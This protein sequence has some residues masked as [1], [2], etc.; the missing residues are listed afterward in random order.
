ML[1]LP[2]EEITKAEVAGLLHDLGHT[3]FSYST[4]KYLKEFYGKDHKDQTADII[5]GAFSNFPVD[6]TISTQSVPSIL[7]DY[8]YD[9]KEIAAIAVKRGAY[10]GPQYLQDMLNQ[11]YDLDVLDSVNRWSDMGSTKVKINPSKMLNVY[12]IYGESLVFNGKRLSEV[13]KLIAARLFLF[14]EKSVEER[15]NFQAVDFMI[16]KAIDMCLQS[17]ILSEDFVLMDDWELLRHLEGHEKANLI[18]SKMKMGQRYPCLV[19]KKIDADAH[20]DLSKCIKELETELAKEMQANFSEVIV[21]TQ[22]YHWPESQ[23]P[24]LTERGLVPVCELIDEAKT[25]DRGFLLL[26][27]HAKPTQKTANAIQHWVRHSFRNLEA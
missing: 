22:H 24:I 18:I 13:R 7:E 6:V 9:P 2:K 10:S 27:Y 8:S 15:A 16:E 26:I 14:L 11:P 23:Y 21:R 1:E 17:G 25:K 5:T 20:K 19:I 12:T 4:E 3:P